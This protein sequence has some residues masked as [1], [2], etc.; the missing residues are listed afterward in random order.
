VD[1]QHPFDIA[2]RIALVTGSTRGIGR[3]FA[4]GLAE[5]GCTVIVHG[6]TSEAAESA[7]AEIGEATGARTHGVAFDVTDPAAVA[8]GVRSIDD[9]VGVPDVLVNNAGIQ[10]R[11]PVVDFAANDWDAVLAANLTAPFLVAQHVAR[12]MVARGSGKIITI[13]SVQSQ[14]GRAGIVPYA[15]TKGG[16]V[17]LTK[18]LCAELGPHGIQAN[19]LAPGYIDTDMNAALVADAAF[20]AWV[21]RRTPAG[22]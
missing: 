12:G 13:G 19:V 22:R 15:A 18:G 16:V 7:A 20:D 4:V 11:A 2:G 3:A 10:R 21:R 8:A 1:Q 17:M 14:L 9:A 6:R 5:A